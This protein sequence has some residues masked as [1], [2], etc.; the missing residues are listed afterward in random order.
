MPVKIDEYDT[1][2][3]VTPEGDF[4]GEDAVDT[5]KRIEEVIDRKHVADVVF[6]MEKCGFID[7]QGLSTL[8]WTRRRCEDLFGQC[9][10][11]N[12]DDNCRK[13]LEITRLS[14]RFDCHD[15]LD[16]ALKTLR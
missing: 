16:S 12:M 10:L 6:D 4:M 14:H 8:L 13:I 7:S 15:A 3:V 1:V 11:A 5:Q 2:C 9:K